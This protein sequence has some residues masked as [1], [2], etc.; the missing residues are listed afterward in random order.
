MEGTGLLTSSTAHLLLMPQILPEALTP[1]GRYPGFF[2]ALSVLGTSGP[3]WGM[4]TDV[5]GVPAAP[6][7]CAT[8]RGQWSCCER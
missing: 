5:E 1:M 2:Q 3:D 4:A 7:L 6:G 8:M